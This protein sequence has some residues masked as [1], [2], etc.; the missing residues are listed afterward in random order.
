MLAVMLLT[1]ACVNDSE[2]RHEQSEEL[3]RVCESIVARQG[4]P[5][6]KVEAVQRRP[7][8]DF[9]P[10][11]GDNSLSAIELVFTTCL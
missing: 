4:L 5:R 6:S 7:L 9:T 1:G 3:R 2:L 11:R 8:S 10:G